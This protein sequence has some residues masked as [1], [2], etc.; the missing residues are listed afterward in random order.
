[1]CDMSKQRIKRVWLVTL[2]LLL[3]GAGATTSGAMVPVIDVAAIAQLISQ[4]LTLEQ[5]LTTLRDQLGQARE[6]YAAITGGRNMEQLLSGTVRNYLP[7]DWQTMVDAMEGASA[8]FQTLS[9]A[10][11]QTLDRE[12]YLSPEQLA[13]MPASL[14]AQVQ[15]QRR[16]IATIQTLAHQALAN[17]SER[18]GALQQLID[19]IPTATDEKAVLDLQARIQVEQGMLENEQTKLHMVLQSAQ[20]EELARQQRARERALESLGSVRALPPMGL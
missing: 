20:A 18:F 19:A 3:T 12:A 8:E 11:Q 17:T 2:L 15:E 14:R 4:L 1:V 6:A 10:V 5:Q 9:A 13:A 16:S 7:A